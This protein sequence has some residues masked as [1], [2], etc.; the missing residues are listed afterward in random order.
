MNTRF[1]QNVSI[2]ITSSGVVAEFT[3]PPFPELWVQDI[4]DM[5]KARLKSALEINPYDFDGD[6]SRFDDG[7][8]V[9]LSVYT[10]C[11]VQQIYQAFYD[12]I[13]EITNKIEEWDALY[14]YIK[15][16]ANAE[17]GGVQ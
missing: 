9:R 17:R 11:P 13:I 16:R 15:M 6:F 4:G 1:V 5:L 3:L 14:E 10:N 8:K 2:K 12:A 7:I